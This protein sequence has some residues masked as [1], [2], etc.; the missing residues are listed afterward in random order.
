[1]KTLT[2][3]V[4]DD[5]YE[6]FKELAAKSGRTTD[7][8]ALQWLARRAERSLAVSTTGD[9]QAARARLLRHAGA[10]NLGYPTG[11]DNE[12]IDADLARE[13]AATHEEPA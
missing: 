11:A 12:S 3:Q 9:R 5:L 13:Y 7:G 8:V 1:M 10:E 4:A 6:A 2:L